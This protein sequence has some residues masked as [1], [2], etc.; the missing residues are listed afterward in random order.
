[1]G[2]A[3]VSEE[4]SFK[5]NKGENNEQVLTISEILAPPPLID[6]GRLGYIRKVKRFARLSITK[7][8]TSKYFLVKVSRHHKTTQ[9]FEFTS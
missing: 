2:D 9:Q 1:M 7:N 6:N 4:P 3:N 8:K 5:K